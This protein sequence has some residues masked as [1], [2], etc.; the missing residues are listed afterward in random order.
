V[1][2]PAPEPLWVEG[3][4]PPAL[5][6]SILRVLY[7]DADWRKNLAQVRRLLI[8]IEPTLHAMMHTHHRFKP[9]LHARDGV[10]RDERGEPIPE[11]HPEVHPEVLLGAR[12]LDSMDERVKSNVLATCRASL[13][14]WA[15]PLVEYA[16]SWLDFSIGTWS[17][18]KRRCR[19]ISSRPRPMP[20][21]LPSW[22]GCSRA[23]RSTA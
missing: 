4:L 16:T 9:D 7:S 1:R 17:A 23:R 15:D 6:L 5:A 22:S 14:L 21:A 18:R 11:V 3:R 20:T 13:S 19:S 10:A 2:L 12:A 8:N